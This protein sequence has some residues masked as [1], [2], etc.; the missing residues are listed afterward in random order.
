[1]ISTRRRYKSFNGAREE[2]TNADHTMWF[3]RSTYLMMQMARLRKNPSTS[4]FR[5][6]TIYLS[7][8][9]RIDLIDYPQQRLDFLIEN[10]TTRTNRLFLVLVV[11]MAGRRL[12]TF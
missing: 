5:Q 10:F 8:D 11:P 7:L 9:Q 2:K 6:C 4:G 12:V 3:V 1:M